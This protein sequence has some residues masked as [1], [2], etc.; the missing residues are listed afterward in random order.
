MTSMCGCSFF[1]R[2]S[3]ITR[4]RRPV[5]SSSSSRIV[6]SS[7]MSTKRTMPGTSVRIGFVYGSH[8]NSTPSRPTFC[9]SSAISVAPSGTWKR[10]WTTSLSA[11]VA[12]AADAPLGL[13]REHRADRHPF[14]PRIFDGLGGIL[15]DQLAGLDQHLGLAELIELVRVGNLL[16]RD[17][18]HEALA[19]RLDDVLA[20]FQRRHLEP[21][22][23]AAVLL[24]DRDVLRHVHESARLVPGVCGLQCRYG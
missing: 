16:A 7:T 11:A 2:S 3:M 14:D 17:A 5:S 4:W 18:A 10:E 22:H 19:Q 12:H 23:R 20:F 15:A 6:S 1:S 9:P 24:G 8:V 13:A 21:A